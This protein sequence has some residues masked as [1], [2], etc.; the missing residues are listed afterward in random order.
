MNQDQSSPYFKDPIRAAIASC[1]D[2]PRWARQCLKWLTI[3]DGSSLE[4]SFPANLSEIYKQSKS[5]HLT[6]LKKKTGIPFES[7][8]FFD[9]EGWNIR[10]VEKLGVKCVY[11]PNGMSR[12]DW[13]KAVKMFD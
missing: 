11:T 5:H 4:S 3:E 9:N 13:D 10:V 6:N 12:S 1:T 2:E 8:V 7:M